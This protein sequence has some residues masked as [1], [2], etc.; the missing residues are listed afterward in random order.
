MTTQL[1]HDDKLGDE[2]Q[3]LKRKRGRPKKQE[4]SVPF[5]GFTQASIHDEYYYTPAIWMHVSAM[6]N[7]LAELK[8]V[9]YV[10]RHTWGHRDY[11]AK[12]ITIDEFMNGR[13][14]TRGKRKGQR[15]DF[16]TGLSESAVRDGLERAA[17]HGFLDCFVDDSDKARIGKYYK[18]RM[19]EE[20]A[21]EGVEEEVEVYL[22]E[23]GISAEER[24]VFASDKEALA[25]PE[26]EISAE[27]E[28][29]EVV[30]TPHE[31]F[32]KQGYES[33]RIFWEVFRASSGR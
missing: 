23:E 21:Y 1:C 33:S 18:L 13:I 9:Q 7:N 11:A 24:G 22:E 12:H 30:N 26:E 29:V 2:C 31:V 27:E 14:Y 16:G 6:I 5:D 28:L 32:N 17:K 3:P 19:Q 15:M 10:M 25:Y 4:S 8:V 20:G